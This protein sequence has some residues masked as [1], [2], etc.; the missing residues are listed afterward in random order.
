MKTTNGKTTRI[1]NGSQNTIKSNRKKGL[2]GIGVA[3][4][5]SVVVVVVV[6]VVEASPV[7]VVDES[8]GFQSS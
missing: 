8:E 4:G 6:V 1:F 2:I 3:S 5:F 7:G